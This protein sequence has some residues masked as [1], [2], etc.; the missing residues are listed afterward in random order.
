MFKSFKRLKNKGKSKKEPTQPGP[1]EIRERLRRLDEHRYLKIAA[2]TMDPDEVYRRVEA[3]HNTPPV[4][5]DLSPEQIQ[6]HVNMLINHK[7]SPEDFVAALR[8]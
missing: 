5:S 8:G 2:K 7:P 3:M 1:K 4:S 6:E